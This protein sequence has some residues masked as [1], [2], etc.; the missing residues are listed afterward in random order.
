MGPPAHSAPDRDESS[1]GENTDVVEIK[2]EVDENASNA[3]VLDDGLANERLEQFAAQ[4]RLLRTLKEKATQFLQDA[5]SELQ[6]VDEDAKPTCDDEALLRQELSNAVRSR[7]DLAAKLLGVPQLA[8]ANHPHNSSSK[9]ELPPPH[10]VSHPVMWFLANKYSPTMDSAAPPPIQGNAA[11]SIEKLEADLKHFLENTPRQQL[12]VKSV[13][14]LHTV[15]YVEQLCRGFVTVQDIDSLKTLTALVNEC[16]A[17]IAAVEASSR[18]P[19][20]LLRE[21]KQKIIKQKRDAAV[22]AAGNMER[23][24]LAKQRQNIAEKAAEAVGSRNKLVPPVYLLDFEVVA[25]FT[26]VTKVNVKSVTSHDFD[27]P[28]YMELNDAISDVVTNKVVQSLLEDFTKAC[29]KSRQYKDTNSHVERI[30]AANAIDELQSLFELCIAGSPVDMT[31]VSKSVQSGLFLTGVSPKSMTAALT[32]NCTGMLHLQY[33]GEVS[34]LLI[35]ASDL[36]KVAGEDI[37][38]AGVAS[39]VESLDRDRVEVLTQAGVPFFSSKQSPMSILYAPTGYV[40]VDKTVSGVAVNSVRKAVLHRSSK[41]VLNGSVAAG[42]LRSQPGGAKLAQ[43][44][45][46]ARPT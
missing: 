39:Y 6:H 5:D 35:P 29:K 27:T 45:E 36:Q 18:K 31:P 9:P 26:P 7:A 4:S 15:G 14:S 17:T 37:E 32:P 11:S 44:I 8:L 28:Y 12:P 16:V 30:S 1:D 2:S 13:Q 46:L 23:E 24:T 38:T 25:A 43:L 20:K 34:S 40:V 22:K 41:S 33:H 10:V 3:G 19:L 42:W 21:H